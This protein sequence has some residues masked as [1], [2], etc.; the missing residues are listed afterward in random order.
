MEIICHHC[1]YK[2]NYKGKSEHECA[3]PKCRYRINLKPYIIEQ[4]KQQLEEME[5]EE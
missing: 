1:D 3:C 2:W 5:E 4:L